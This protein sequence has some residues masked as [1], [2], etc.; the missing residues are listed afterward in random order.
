MS[1]YTIDALTEIIQQVGIDW[2]KAIAVSEVGERLEYEFDVGPYDFLSFA[3]R[4]L[5]DD[6]DRALVNALSNAKRAIDA[7]VDKILLCFGIPINRR[8]IRSKMEFL[9]QV[10]VVAPRIVRKVRDARNYLEHEY[11]LPTR[12]QVQDAVDIASLF[13]TASNEALDFA[14]Y[15]V[16]TNSDTPMERIYGYRSAVF[17]NFDKDE[18]VFKVGGYR[19]LETVQGIEATI[20]PDDNLYPCIIKLHLAAKR[21]RKVEKALQELRAVL[22]GP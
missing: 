17:S 13:V 9:Q 15:V 5:E 4:D 12:E 14:T 8:G 19:E 16:L 10:N 3:E 18:K 6:S 22:Q 1:D 20:R 2:E 21:D 7:Q 11:K